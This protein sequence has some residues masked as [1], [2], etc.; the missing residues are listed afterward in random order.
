[1]AR[2]TRNHVLFGHAFA[3]RALG[4]SDVQGTL[5]EG[6]LPVNGLKPEVGASPLLGGPQSVETGIL[7]QIR[8]HKRGGIW[9]EKRKDSI[10]LMVEVMHHDPFPRNLVSP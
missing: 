4:L 8:G 3:E 9:A 5:E 6:F 10:P 1:M 2:I 7:R